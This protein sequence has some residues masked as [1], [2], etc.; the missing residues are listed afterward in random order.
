[1]AEVEAESARGDTQQTLAYAPSPQFLE[2]DSINRHD[3]TLMCANCRK[4]PSHF[5]RLREW[6]AETRAARHVNFFIFLYRKT[7]R[8]KK[9]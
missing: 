6:L 8:K 9:R 7:K 2:G 5:S 4:K 1:M 3:E